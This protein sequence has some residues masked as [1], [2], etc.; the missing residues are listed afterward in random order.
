[1]D[2]E[3]TMDQV[4][5]TTTDN[6]YNPFEEFDEWVSF[7]EQ[8]GYYTLGYLARI[9]KS[10]P[11]LPDEMVSYHIREAIDEIVKLNLLGIYKKVT[12]KDYK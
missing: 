2:K 1:M 6:P 10:S 11:T 9:V 8:Q 12:P 4:M 3:D 5:L 7:D